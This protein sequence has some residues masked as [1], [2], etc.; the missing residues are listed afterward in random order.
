MVQCHSLLLSY[1]IC[2]DL[3]AI[4]ILISSW[5]FSKM[6][7]TC[8]VLPCYHGSSFFSFFFGATS[9]NEIHREIILH[10]GKFHVME[11]FMRVMLFF[12]FKHSGSKQTFW[13]SKNLLASGWDHKSIFSLRGYNLHVDNFC[14]IFAFRHFG[15]AVT[16]FWIDFNL[17][18]LQ[19]LVLGELFVALT[20]NYC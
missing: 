11:T 16:S 9:N 4:C 3:C 15:Y 2:T 17:H 8:V 7:V 20:F 12:F 1:R 18:W 10:I 14:V 19:T 5:K 6:M 13:Q